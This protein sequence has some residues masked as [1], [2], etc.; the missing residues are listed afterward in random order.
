[1][2]LKLKRFTKINLKSFVMVRVTTW[3]WERKALNNFGRNVT[4]YRSKKD[5]VDL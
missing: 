5:F 2:I 1:M 4:E 3:V